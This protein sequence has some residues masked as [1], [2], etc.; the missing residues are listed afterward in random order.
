MR[1]RP[2]MYAEIWR[3]FDKLFKLASH[4]HQ[5]IKYIRMQGAGIRQA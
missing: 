3:L 4:M 5:P 1:A 2:S